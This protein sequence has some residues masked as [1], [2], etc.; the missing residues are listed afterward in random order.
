MISSSNENFSFRELGEKEIFDPVSLCE[1][2]SFTQAKFYGDWQKKLG[3]AVKRFVISHNDDPLVYFQLIKYPLFGKHSCL[4]LPY[5]P[6][7]KEY[8]PELVRFLFAQIKRITRKENAVFARIDPTPRNTD[9]E[10]LFAQLFKKA[11]FYTYHSSYYQPRKEWHLDIRQNDT[12]LLQDM[13][14]NTRYSVRLAEKRGVEVEII[15]SHFADY[16]ENFYA[17]MQETAGRNKFRLHPKQYYEAIFETLEKDSTSYLVI[18]RY[19]KK[20]LVIDVMI[21]FGTIMNYV[22]GTSSN[23]HRETLPSYMAQWEAIQYAKKLGYQRYNFGGISLGENKNWEGLSLFKRR[24]GGYIVKHSEFY[25]VIVQ[26]FWYQVYVARKFLA[27]F[28]RDKK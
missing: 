28:L 4:Y 18:A 27:H 11:A 3:R 15:T 20:I 13:H 10:K 9:E 2:S 8:S 5:G 21:A 23:E 12:Q 22:F 17:L 19:Q 25:D 24:W 6:V 26:P 16:F 14:K 1:E 7:F